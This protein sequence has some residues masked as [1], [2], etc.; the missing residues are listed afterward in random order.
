MSS[1]PIMAVTLPP[2]ICGS[3]TIEER[4][5]IEFTPNVKVTRVPPDVT[6]KQGDIHYQSSYVQ[7]GNKVEV[8]R[9]LYT[10]R[11]SAVCQAEELE[12]LKEFFPIFLS[13][14]RSQIFYE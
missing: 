6:Y 11:P 9:A 14:M 2:Y 5:S 1:N 13:D 3:R 7:N 4:Y 8:K 10:Q 12:Q